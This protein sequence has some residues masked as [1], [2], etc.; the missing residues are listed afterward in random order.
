MTEPSPVKDLVCLVADK[1]MEQTLL[2]L[3]NR[4][5][6][7]GI[8]AP[9]F[10]LFVHEERD[11]G[12]CHHGAEFLRAFS[13]RYRHA[14]LLFDYEGCG[15]ENVPSKDLEL[16]LESQLRRNGWDDRARVIAI[17]PELEA[18]VWSDSPEVDAILGWSGRIPDLRSWLEQEGW[19]T[20][21]ASKPER[22]KEAVEA[23]LYKVRQPRSS[24]TYRKLAEG[25]SLRRCQDRKF[26]RLKRSLRRWFGA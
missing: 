17:E 22:P 7:L 11:P 15:Q 14:L 10:D 20:R 26:A 25:V 8:R 3:L 6:A 23:A 4:P 9:S 19:L 2:G 13:S 18:W 24:A 12:C 16:Q 1:N 21:S 5:E